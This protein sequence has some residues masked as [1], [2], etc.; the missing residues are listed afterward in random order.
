MSIIDAISDA[1]T[2]WHTT[3]EERGDLIEWSED[4]E[5][6]SIFGV[7]NDMGIDTTEDAEGDTV[8]RVWIDQESR[9]VVDEVT[10]RRLILATV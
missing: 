1:Y 4:G 2:E 3:P 7:R 10:L 8:F 5:S 9:I 6:V